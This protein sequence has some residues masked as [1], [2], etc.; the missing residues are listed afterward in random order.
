MG[1]PERRPVRIAHILPWPSVGGTEAA[2]M[3]LARAIEGDE[4]SS[5]AFCLR[6]AQPVRALFEEAGIPVVEYEAAEPSLRHPWPFLRSSIALARQLRAA[7]VSLVHAAD[8]LAAHRSSLAVILARLPFITHVRGRFPDLSRRDRIFLIPVRRFVFVAQ[9]TWRVFGHRVPDDR[10]E[11]LYDGI[12]VRHGGAG[13]GD[14]VRREL[15]ISPSAPVIGMVARVAPA[16]DYDTL[17]RAAAIVV[18]RHPDAKFLVV[19]QHSGVREYE[20]HYRLVRRLIDERALSGQ[21]IFTGHRADVDRLLDAMDVCVLATHGEGL[22]LGLL[23]AMA[24][25]KPVVATAVGG[26]PELVQHEQTGLLV[27]PSDHDA[28]ARALSRLLGDPSYAR[29]LGA[30]GRAFVERDFGHASFVARLRALYS[31]VLAE[32]SRFFQS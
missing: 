26:I 19:G 20:Q 24:V 32:K 17:I 12:D 27:L 2:T 31:R 28:L 14:A 10:G 8:I 6:G 16:K 15:G 21:F 1:D 13:A 7:D 9:D 11:V 25:G 18:S 5:V 22:P 29:M 3:R 30:S 4:F 23:E